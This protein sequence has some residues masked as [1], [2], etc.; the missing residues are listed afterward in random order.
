MLKG[1]I[2]PAVSSEPLVSIL[3]LHYRSS[4]VEYVHVRLD[5]HGS[6]QGMNGLMLSYLFVVS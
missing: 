3:P 2:Y 5:F 4:F 6:V 1:M